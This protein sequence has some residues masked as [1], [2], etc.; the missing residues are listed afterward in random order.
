MR[1]YIAIDTETSGLDPRYD[2]IVEIACVRFSEDGQEISR[3][4]SLVYPECVISDKLISIHGITN[5]M[6]ADAP[7]FEYVFGE[8]AN[9]I[10][11]ADLGD[12]SILMAHNAQFDVG[13]I[14][15]EINRFTNQI[16]YLAEVVDTLHLS[17]YKY[18]FF[19]NHKLGTLAEKLELPKHD[20]HRA[21]GDCLTLKDVWVK[22]AF[23]LEHESKYRKYKITSR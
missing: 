7:R 22:S 5:E 15:E 10:F 19:Q 18:R 9:F 16:S 3:F 12:S 11:D 1:E 20:A 2:R 14:N 8:F 13:F 21:L 4:Q 23:H 6:V 17:R